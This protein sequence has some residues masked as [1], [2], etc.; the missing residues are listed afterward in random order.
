MLRRR[1]SK[2]VTGAIAAAAAVIGLT[3]PFGAWS[4]QSDAPVRSR[5]I[6][7]PTR[8]SGSP[9][10]LQRPAA[11]WSAWSLDRAMRRVDEARVVAAGRLLHVDS[12]TTLCSGV[13]KALGRRHERRWYRFDCTYTLFRNGIDQDIEFRLTPLGPKRFVI[14]SARWMLEQR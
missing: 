7:T 12:A 5:S 10:A 8:T 6:S 13:G 11:R 14:D 4:G 1:A 9:A 3:I 2:W